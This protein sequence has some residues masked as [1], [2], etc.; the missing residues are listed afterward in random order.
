M[1]IVELY[2]NDEIDIDGP[3]IQNLLRRQKIQKVNQ[4][5]VDE[6]KGLKRDSENRLNTISTL[7]KSGN[8]NPLLSE[9]D[10]SLQKEFDELE[11]FFED[12]ISDIETKIFLFKAVA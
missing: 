9:N 3:E 10:N 1:V 8:Y 7:N 11:S 4:R 5:Y 6:L 12:I 2:L